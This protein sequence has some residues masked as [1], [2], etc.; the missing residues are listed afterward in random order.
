MAFIEMITPEKSEGKLKEIYDDIIKKRGMVAEVLQVQSLN[1]DSLVD[2]LNSYMTIMFKKSPL[3]RAQREMLAVVV[4][5]LNGCQYC[6]THH[7]EA[8][9]YFWKDAEKVACLKRSPEN[10][11]LPEA[12]LLL[13]KYAI[14]LTRHPEENHLEII[15][16][17]RGNGFT[18]KAVLDATLVIGYFNFVNRMVQGLGVKLGNEDHTKY[19][20]D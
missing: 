4:S 16:E 8:L 10:I 2:H 7:G 9:D 12:E 14:G 17:L 1:P 5:S 18:D 19:K 6:Q 15:N 11:E 3:S 20:H 13:I